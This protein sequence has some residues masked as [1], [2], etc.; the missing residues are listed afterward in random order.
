MTDRNQP[1][2]SNDLRISEG[3]IK[4]PYRRSID[5]FVGTRKHSVGM[6]LSRLTA[7]LFSL[8]VAIIPRRNAA[9]QG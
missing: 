6:Q 7:Y 5:E 1:A 2:A 4:C 9:S 8:S 3:H